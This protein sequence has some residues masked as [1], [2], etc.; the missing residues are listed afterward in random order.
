MDTG[1]YYSWTHRCPSMYCTHAFAYMCVV[2]LTSI[3]L[4]CLVKLCSSFLFPSTAYTPSSLSFPPWLL[5]LSLFFYSAQGIVSRL[6]MFS[7]CVT[8]RIWSSVLSMCSCLA[9]ASVPSAH[10]AFLMP[11]EEISFLMTYTKVQLPSSP[12]FPVHSR[13]TASIFL[14]KS[15]TFSAPCPPL[16]VHT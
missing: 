16:S 5:P 11:L 12:S 4:Q 9:L 14:E 13:I 1:F 6:L 10:Q 7:S 2:T 8:Y 15:W 3:S